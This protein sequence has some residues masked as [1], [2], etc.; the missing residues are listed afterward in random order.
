MSILKVRRG[1]PCR[2][3]QGEHALVEQVIAE[4]KA[5]LLARLPSGSDAANAAW[6]AYALITFT[7]ARVIGAATPGVYGSSESTEGARS[8]SDPNWCNNPTKSSL[9]HHSTIMPSSSR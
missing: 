6:L 4:L 7:L 1:D 9:R 3:W 5:G 2:V 8:G